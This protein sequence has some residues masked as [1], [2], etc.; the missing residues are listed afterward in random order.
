MKGRRWEIPRQS[1]DGRGSE[2]RTKRDSRRGHKS[3]TR[4]RPSADPHLHLAAVHI[5]LGEA[6]RTVLEEAADRTLA[7]AVDRTAAEE[8]DAGR[9]AAVEEAARIGLEE[10]GRTPVEADQEEVH[11]R[12]VRKVA[13]RE[14]RVQGYRTDT[15]LAEV[16]VH[17]EEGRRNRR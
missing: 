11:I 1:V 4:S 3:V 9:T 6:V 8:A 10:A 14:L 17:L 2:G 12:V 13:G 16:E 15:L 7:E 5:V